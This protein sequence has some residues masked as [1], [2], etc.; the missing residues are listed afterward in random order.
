MNSLIKK[1][2]NFIFEVSS[3]MTDKWQQTVQGAKI[4][5]T[6]KS[7]AVTEGERKECSAA[8]FLMKTIDNITETRMS[9]ATTTTICLSLS[10]GSEAPQ[11]CCCTI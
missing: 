5:E 2:D 3:I 10:L 1:S 6:H 4:D 9:K 7:Y 11:R 8:E